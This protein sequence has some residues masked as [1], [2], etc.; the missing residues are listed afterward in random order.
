MS[1]GAADEEDDEDILNW[2]L[3]NDFDLGEEFRDTLVP[4]ALYW[5]TEEARETGFVSDDFETEDEDEDEDE[6]EE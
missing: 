2:E 1:A 4:D 5:Y 3:S 6:D